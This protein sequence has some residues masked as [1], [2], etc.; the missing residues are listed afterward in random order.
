MLFFKF[1]LFIDRKK[2][3]FKSLCFLDKFVIIEKGK[4]DRIVYWLVIMVEDN[5]GEVFEMEVIV[6]L[7]N[8]L[9][10]ILVEILLIVILYKFLEGIYDVIFIVRDKSRNL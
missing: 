7:I 10:N 2:L 6:I 1:F 9:M 8:I 5:D 3:E 4:M